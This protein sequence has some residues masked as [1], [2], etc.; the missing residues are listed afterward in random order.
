MAK[1]EAERNAKLE[2]EKEER[3]AAEIKAI[4]EMRD[5][6]HKQKTSSHS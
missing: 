5:E 6:S 4:A 3:R 1:D 2:K